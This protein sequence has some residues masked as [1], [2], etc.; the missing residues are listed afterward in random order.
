MK[1]FNRDEFMAKC[2]K[3]KKEF[4]ALEIAR[5]L[6]HALDQLEVDLGR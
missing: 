3:L 4:E 5:Q 1:T 2:E 6:R